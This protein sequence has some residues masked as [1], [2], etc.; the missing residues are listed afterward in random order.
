[1]SARTSL[2]FRKRLRCMPDVGQGHGWDPDDPDEASEWLA[3]PVRQVALTELIAVN[4]K[5]YLSED[6]VAGYMLHSVTE[7]PWILRRK[8]WFSSKY[9]VVDGHHRCVAAWRAGKNT[10]KAR[11]LTIG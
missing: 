1:V 2:P 10:I 5:R 7:L 11:V 3:A 4:R 9:Y 8:G 6:I